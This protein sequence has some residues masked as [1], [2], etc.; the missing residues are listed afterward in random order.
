MTLPPNRIIIFTRYP[1]PGAT[2]TRL[3][4]ALGP[5]GA[6]DLQRSLT[7]RIYRQAFAFS[8][9]NRVSIEICVKDGDEKKMRTWLGRGFEYS[10]QAPGDLGQSMETA[11]TNAFRK[12]S[13]R[14]ILLGT[15]IPELGEKQHLEKGFE[16]LEKN[17]LVLGPSTDG[18]YYLVGLRRNAAIFEGVSWGRTTVLDQ[19]LGLAHKAGL[20]IHTLEPLTDI[21]TEQDLDLLPA[22]KIWKKPYVSVII[23]TLNEQQDIRKAIASAVDAD[24]EILVVDGGSRDETVAIA[25]RSGR[26]RGNRPEEEGRHSRTWG[27]P[28]LPDAFFCFFMRIPNSPPVIQPT[29]SMPSWIPGRLSARFDSKRTATHR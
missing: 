20:S 4:P 1:V 22:S 29:F 3:I 24:A 6:A 28:L 19:T 11:F 25:K 12:G 9:K 7:E 21:D 10:R 27:H 2:K 14:V 5:V 16:A 23:P 18:G 15:D 8:T 17:D 13:R 26:P